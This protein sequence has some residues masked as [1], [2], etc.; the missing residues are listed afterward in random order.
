MKE[1]DK[2]TLDL[3]QD[4][5]EVAELAKAIPPKL[6]YALRRWV[7]KYSATKPKAMPKVKEM[8]T[9]KFEEKRDL[10][11]LAKSD[12]M[13]STFDNGGIRMDFGS[14]V[15][16]KIK[17]AALEWAKKRGLRAIE[18]SMAKSSDGANTTSVIF[19]QRVD[20]ALRVSKIV[21]EAE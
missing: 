9:A 21:L 3:V 16:E 10:E 19:N 7:E 20:G 1:I 6:R 13:V 4:Q 12:V 5:I 14:A 11:T 8:L 17:K 18:E 15:P 2:L